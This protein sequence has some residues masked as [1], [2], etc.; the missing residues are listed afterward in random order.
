MKNQIK[1]PNLPVKPAPETD[2]V[3]TLNLHDTNLEMDKSI[4]DNSQNAKDIEEQFKNLGIEL[5]EEEE[6]DTLHDKLRN[7]V[8]N[9][10]MVYDDN[11]VVRGSIPKFKKNIK[12]SEF[13]RQN[14]GKQ[15]EMEKA[16]NR[17]MNRHSHNVNADFNLYDDDFDKNK[18]EQDSPEKRRKK[19]TT[20]N[21]AISGNYVFAIQK[22]NPSPKKMPNPPVKPK[23]K[24]MSIMVNYNM[25]NMKSDKKIDSNDSRRGGRTSEQV[26]RFGKKEG[27]VKITRFSNVMDEE[28]MEDSRKQ[29]S[30][31]HLPTSVYEKKRNMN[32]EFDKIPNIYGGEKGGKPKGEVY[33]VVEAEIKKLRDQQIELKRQKERDRQLE[34]KRILEMQR[35][36]QQKEKEIEEERIRQEQLRQEQQREEQQRQEQLRQEQ[37]RQEQLRQE[38]QRQEQQRQKQQRQEQQ[39]QEQQREEQQRQEQLKLEQQKIEEEKE[40]QRQ[41]EIEA[42]NK[43]LEALNAE[44]EKER[45]K[46]EEIENEKQRYRQQ[47]LDEEKMRLEQQKL[48]EEQ[49][50][51]NQLKEEKKRDQEKQR[52]LLED[53]RNLPLNRQQVIN[54][55]AEGEQHTTKVNRYSR[56]NQIYYQDSQQ[57]GKFDRIDDQGR[58]H[59]VEH[60]KQKITE[61]DRIAQ[62]KLYKQ[63]QVPNNRRQSNT[64]SINR[65]SHISNEIGQLHTRTNTGEYGSVVHQRTS[66]THGN[67]YQSQNNAYVQVPVQYNSFV[68]RGVNQYQSNTQ[69]RQQSHQYIPNPSDRYINQYNTEINKGQQVYTTNTRQPPKLFRKA[70]S[71]EAPPVGN[72]NPKNIQLYNEKSYQKQSSYDYYQQPGNPPQQNQ[73][74]WVNSVSPNDQQYAQSNRYIVNNQGY[75]RQQNQYMSNKVIPN[76]QQGNVQRKLIKCTD[77]NGK[78]FYKYA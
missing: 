9:D 32:E 14:T 52:Q 53:Q 51:I 64:Q 41:L 66:Q 59:E 47:E 19:R 73:V 5:N 26:H 57:I 4:S 12:F 40:K 49:K 50:R 37:Q 78:E 29:R 60:E 31:S 36:K 22:K 42:E 30:R 1:E 7:C 61:M 63:Q 77:A 2:A 15:H 69:A 3:D 72:S 58:L 16:R 75:Q 55:I 62:E 10:V 20:N 45:Q 44:K 48:Q 28:R 34:E 54:R 27:S 65:G 13:L 67:V 21:T 68:H 23:N 25:L 17:I 33:Q 56:S 38:Q 43:R 74:Q 39:R 6:R 76:V 46:Q 18:S 35:E 70:S 71:F 8:D 11:K 24:N